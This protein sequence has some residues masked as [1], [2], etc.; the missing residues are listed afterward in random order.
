MSAALSSQLFKDPEC[1]SGLA[2]NPQF[3]AQRT[4][5]LPAELARQRLDRQ[6]DSGFK[7]CYM[8]FILSL[9]GV[10]VIPEY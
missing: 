7:F 4:G 5:A 2:L 1:W 10:E 9:L 6:A 8:C 3:P